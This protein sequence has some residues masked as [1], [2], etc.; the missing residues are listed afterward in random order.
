MAYVRIDDSAMTNLKIVRS[1]DSA[2][3]LWMKGLCYCQMHLTDGFI[4]TEA[5]GPMEAKR[6]DIDALC[7]VL[8]EGKAELWQRV[9]GGFMV[10][11]YFDHNDSKVVVEER[12]RKDRERKRRPDSDLDSERSSERTPSEPPQDFPFNSIRGG[13][14]SNR[15]IGKEPPL[16]LGLR[17]FSVW[18]WQLETL[19]SRLGIHSESFRI[20]DWLQALDRDR[21]R[22]IPRDSWA[23]LQVEFDAEVQ[24]RG[25][26]VAS[27]QSD[28]PQ[29]GK[30]TTRMATLV[31]NAQ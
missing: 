14:S 31:R 22:V 19:I 2:F 9:P 5:L 3:R 21:S 16:A 29:A 27:T 20:D 4:P 7:S 15:R 18:R 11:D 17:R 13:S 26:P 12:K 28:A 8:V 23:W 6:K 25:L 24:R 10:H 30:L 1:P